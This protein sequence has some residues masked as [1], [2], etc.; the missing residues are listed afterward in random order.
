MHLYAFPEIAL[1]FCFIFSI[2][3]I[4]S[5]FLLCILGWN[6]TWTCFHRFGIHINGKHKLD[7]NEI[8]VRIGLQCAFVERAWS[9]DHQPHKG[10]ERTGRDQVPHNTS[11]LSLFTSDS[12]L[13]PKLTG[14]SSQWARWLSAALLEE[15]WSLVW[16]HLYV[17]THKHK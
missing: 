9:H 3:N 2:Q 15:L 12:S 16:P 13:S 6:M 7:I 4:F 8:T 10:N 1:T 17:Q 5:Y 14:T 11:S